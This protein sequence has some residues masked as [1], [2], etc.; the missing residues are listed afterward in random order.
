M[1]K[2]RT[3]GLLAFALIWLLCTAAGAQQEKGTI[4]IEALD[5]TKFTLTVDQIRQ[6]PQQSVSIVNPHT[7]VTEKYEGVLLADVLAKANTPSG[8]KLR[9]DEMRD[10][11]EVGGRD[12]YKAVF[13]LAELDPAFQDSK[14]LVAIS[15]DGKPLDEKLGPVR[16][17]V[18]QD[19]RPARSVRMV[20]TIAVRRAP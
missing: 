20:M 10:Y 5:G 18:P 14:V 13:A 8:D 6:M 1:R 4:M 12:G 15:S 9:G 3:T 17:V 19:K 11:V 2:K 16:I 7:K